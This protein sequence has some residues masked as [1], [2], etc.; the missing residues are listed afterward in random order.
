MKDILILLACVTAYTLAYPTSVQ[1]EK[2]PTQ[3][4]SHM[5]QLAEEMARDLGGEENLAK[6]EKFAEMMSKCDYNELIQAMAR[7][8]ESDLKFIKVMSTGKKFGNKN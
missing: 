4:K 8:I 1:D 2:V 5:N 6:M 7:A 3:T